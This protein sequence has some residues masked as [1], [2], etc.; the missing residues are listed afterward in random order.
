MDMRKKLQNTFDVA[1]ARCNE[2]AKE[3]HAVARGALKMA[4]STA[5]RVDAG[6]CSLLEEIR[7]HSQKE[8]GLEV[9]V[10]ELGERIGPQIEECL[11]KTGR[12]LNAKR[13]RMRKFTLG[14]FGRTMAGKSTFRE[15]ITGGSGETIGKGAQ[16]TTKRTHEYLWNGLYIVDTPGFG[17]AS[18]GK[19]FTQ[20]ALS[21]IDKS[22][23]VL[24]L[25]R[26]DGI[27]E[28]VFEG[29]RAIL[30]ENKPVFFILNVM[31]NLG[32]ELN[33]KRFLSNSNALMGGSR[34]EGH[35]R[36]IHELAVQK[37]GV[38]E[39]R[40]F[41][42][43]AQAAFMATRPE[44]SAEK[45]RRFSAS[46]MEGL[47]A[48][49]REEVAVHG[50]VR[51]LQTCI[52]GTIGALMDLK[53]FYNAQ[54]AK[55]EEKGDFL[56][57]K[58]VD[59][60]L[61]TDAFEKD[62]RKRLSNDVAE[63]FA[64]LRNQVFQF[65]EDNIENKNIGAEWKNRTTA[66]RIE[67]SVKAVQERTARVAQDLVQEF[68][69]EIQFDTEFGHVAT[70]AEPKSWSG[71]DSKRHL[72]WASLFVSLFALTNIWNPVGWLLAGGGLQILSWFSK[73]KADQVGKAK[74]EARDQLRA[75]LDSQERELREK[76]IGWFDRHILEGCLRGVTLG[77]TS[78]QQ[79]LNQVGTFLKRAEQESSEEID[80]LNRHLLTRTVGLNGIQISIKS[81]ARERGFATRAICFPAV[82]HDRASEIA[83]RALAED[84]LV[85]PDGPEMEL[86]RKSLRLEKG[87]RILRDGQR[88]STRIPTEEVNAKKR[89]LV[90]TEK[91]IKKKIKLTLTPV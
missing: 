68:R 61:R 64:P 87:Q 82:E 48:A 76:L 40:I 52:D 88:L 36:R 14:L 29:M 21:V 79:S 33:R 38:H 10:K 69:K 47:H 63:I 91:L 1:L 32:D 4:H 30:R 54:H 55:L 31:R 11:G 51:R 43:H 49:L 57:K 42:I 83:S 34:I 81:I 39:V 71:W 23:V 22:D 89:L 20:Q 72:G 53:D 24:F 35:R 86:V 28:D 45:D 65:I 9:A 41:P 25:L 19:R 7:E 62:H 50:P 27:Q 75:S 44:W 66:A 3:E 26:E 78:I 74:N 73:K 58:V 67:E 70:A 90:V 13:I 60:K 8:G 56:Q 17:A 2:T 5:E 85:A 84:V 80:R 77:L 18:H 15:A 16:N 12:S 46:G 59:F 37:L 6:I